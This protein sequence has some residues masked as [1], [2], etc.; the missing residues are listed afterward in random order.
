M[1]TVDEHISPLPCLGGIRRRLLQLGRTGR[2]SVP[3]RDA[4]VALAPVEARFRELHR[5]VDDAAPV[6]IELVR[7]AASNPPAGLNLRCYRHALLGRLVLSGQS[8][9]VRV[10]VRRHVEGRIDEIRP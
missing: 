1:S 2:N 9:D 8:V 3:R 10:N 7:I 5:E 4:E 6:A